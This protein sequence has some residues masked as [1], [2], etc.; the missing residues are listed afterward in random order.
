MAPPRSP[1]VGFVGAACSLAAVFAASGSPIPLYETYR[2]ADGL[3][4]GDLALTAV[5]YFAGA[6]LALLSLGRLS[7]HLGRRP[8][9]LA[10]LALSAAG[11]LVLVEVHGA[12][13]LV[14]GRVLQGLACGLASSAVAA[15]AVD[16]APTRPRWL[17]AATTA[18]APMIGLTVGAL[19]SGALAEYGPAP[20][21]LVY[22]LAAGL[23]A[24]CAV[25]VAV[26]PETVAGTPGAAA[27]LRP[28]VRIPPGA[29]RFLPVAG[30]TFLATWALGGF[31]QAFGPTVAADQLGTANAL[32]AAA[33]FASLMAPSA[34]GGPLAGRLTPATAQ[35]VGMVVHL[36]AVAVVLT[37]LRLGTVLLFL[38]ASAVAGAAQ[39]ATMTGSMRALLA[40][41]GP[42]DRAG[43]LAAVYLISYGGAAIPGLIAGRLSANL[44]LFSIA[45]GYGILTALA[46]V[47]TLAAARNPAPR[48]ARDV[49][50]IEPAGG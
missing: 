13:T 43:L 8:V 48:P 16:T 28:Q 44:D 45:V 38:V 18:G 23:L 31:Y 6:M 33:V 40:H 5:A 7:D 21:T 25:L 32:V 27:S 26:A 34:V 47:V 22:L 41:T 42:A 14:T 15:Y 24:G 9:T 4:T 29:R 10:A 12:G 36:L 35:R 17:A 11:C 3:T 50:P 19:A 37:S 2:R 1:V 39:G 49:G 30:A 20:R 46:C